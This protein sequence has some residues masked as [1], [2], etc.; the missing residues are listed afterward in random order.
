MRLSQKESGTSAS[1]YA[2]ATFHLGE[3]AR[4]AGHPALAAHHYRNA[5]D[6]DPTYLPALAGQARLA[7]GR[8]DLET[9]EKDYLRVV[10]GLPLTEYVVELGELYESTGRPQLAQ[11]QYAVATASARLLAA[12]GVATDLETA[13]FQADHGS[14]AEALAAAR[15]EWARRQSIHSADALAWALHAAGRDTA[16]LRYARQA[17]RLGTRD[18]RLRFH[19]GAIEAANDLPSARGTLR[20]ARSLDAGVSPFRESAIATLLA[21]LR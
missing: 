14:P 6:A 16:A 15:A 20:D 5:L 19:L 18:A 3:L 4:A 13:V 21:G 2:Y 17:N 10:Q 8:G 9:A 7:V 12:N 11:E 1:S